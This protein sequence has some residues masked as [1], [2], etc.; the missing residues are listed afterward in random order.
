MAAMHPHKRLRRERE[1]PARAAATLAAVSM[2]HESVLDVVTDMGGA[3][4]ISHRQHVGVKAENVV[5]VSRSAHAH[6]SV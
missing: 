6:Y 1:E 3:A 5:M 2:S 4:H